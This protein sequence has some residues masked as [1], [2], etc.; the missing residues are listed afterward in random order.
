MK[1]LALSSP[2]CDTG[3]Q[4]VRAAVS[5][6]RPSAR[7]T[8]PCHAQRGC[9]A[10]RGVAMITAVVLVGLVG[11]V[12]LALTALL[13]SDVRRTRDTQTDAQL[14]EL[15][16]IAAADAQQRLARDGAAAQKVAIG[17]PPPLTEHGAEVVYDITIEGNQAR[18]AVHAHFDS[19][20]ARQVLLFRNEN[21]TWSIREAALE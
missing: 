11:V 2:P 19:A 20:S 17:L 15:L 18:V 9:A 6:R 1:T 8:N 16:R 13:T 3:F 5:V 12:A 14:H 10:R 4:P 21:N 7:G